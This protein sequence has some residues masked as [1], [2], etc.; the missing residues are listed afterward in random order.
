MT[1]SPELTEQLRALIQNEGFT[2]FMTLVAAFQVLLARYSKQDDIV[3]GTNFAGRNHPEL[4]NMIGFFINTV[5]I[6]TDLSGNPTLHQVLKRVREVYL[7]AHA[8]QDVSFE[9]LVEVLD[10]KRSSSY[11]PIFQFKIDLVRNTKSALNFSSLSSKQ[12]EF[13]GDNSRSSFARKQSNISNLHECRGGPSDCPRRRFASAKSP[14]SDCEAGLGCGQ[15]PLRHGVAE[16][17]SGATAAR[18]ERTW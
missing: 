1:I 4:E 11:S 9:K 16:R 5:V 12:F 2:L 18:L 6:R 8:H 7:E 13:D 3:V 17:L 14:A 15:V 10:P